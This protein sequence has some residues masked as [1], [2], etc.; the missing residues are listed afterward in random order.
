MNRF[1]YTGLSLH[2]E[3]CDGCQLPSCS[4]ICDNYN[5]WLI[6]VNREKRERQIQNRFT[7]GDY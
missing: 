6:Q 7:G 4:E 3:I 2:R 5:R 1:G